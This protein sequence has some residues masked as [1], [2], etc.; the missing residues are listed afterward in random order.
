LVSPA[1]AK[2]NDPSRIIG[3]REE[4]SIRR[5]IALVTSVPD[6]KGR[7]VLDVAAFLDSQPLGGFQVRVALL[8][9]SVLFLESFDSNLLG[10]IAPVLTRQWHLL[11]GALGPIFAASFLG[12]LL[13]ALVAGPVA[14]RTGRKP[15][16]LVATVGFGLS[17]LATTQVS[18]LG[19]LFLIRMLTGVGLGA[20]LPNAVALT[21]EYSPTSRRSGMLVLVLCGIT[22]GSIA[23]GLIA[24][25]L[26]PLYGWQ[27]MFWVGGLAPLALVPLL[28]TGL[29]E[30][31]YFL[32]IGGNRDREIAA[33]MNRV[34]P[35]AGVSSDVRFVVREERAPGLSVKHLFDAGRAPV[36]ILLWVV[37]FMNSF[38]IYVFASWLPSL[39]R[40][41]GLTEEASMLTGVAMSAGGLA[42]TLAMGWLL[43]RFSIERMM[44]AVYVAAAGFIALL[45]VVAGERWSMGIVAAAAGFCIVGGQTGAN[46][47]ITYRHPTYIRS[48]ALAWALGSSRIASIVGPMGAGWIISLGWSSR[49]TFLVAVVPALCA[50]LAVLWSARVRVRDPVS[51][52]GLGNLPR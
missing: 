19:A 41:T 9:A 32:A 45:A 34:A 17:A 20:A 1:V 24:A 47:L 23:A 6:Y 39:A 36:T 49:A 42:G 5:S 40:A 8:C 44:A 16:L 52:V 31:P 2:W 27:S 21:A 46:A 7:A 43:D 4:R 28:V 30:S 12:Q 33:I 15:A 51:R 37:V 38:E 50:A 13:G 29:A 35:G 3:D 26:L 25:R 11:P 10:Y 18:S 48:T 14:D 22:L